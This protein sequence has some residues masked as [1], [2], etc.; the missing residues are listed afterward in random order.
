MKTVSG[1][2]T[3]AKGFRAGGV[4]CGIRK[5]RSKRDLGLICSDVKAQAAA[6]YTSNL[7]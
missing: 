1:G 7:V 6:V 2:V 4:H 3:A 5:S